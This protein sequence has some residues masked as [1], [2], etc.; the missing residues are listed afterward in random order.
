MWNYCLIFNLFKF[1]IYNSTKCHFFLQNR[2]L[3]STLKLIVI[4]VCNGFCCYAMGNL[5]IHA[6][7]L[8]HNY[9][10]PFFWLKLH[11][12]LLVY[13]TI[14]LL[15]A[16]LNLL[17]RIEDFSKEKKCL[18]YKSI[19]YGFFLLNRFFIFTLKMSLFKSIDFE[20]GFFFISFKSMC[21]GI[22]IIMGYVNIFIGIL[23]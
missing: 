5:Q 15:W 3:L 19:Q 1:F 16:D 10:L 8:S 4:M 12:T 6:K 9:N 13:F 23:W 22:T 2:M 17:K 11:F 18:T 7:N 20:D 14:Y 21:Y